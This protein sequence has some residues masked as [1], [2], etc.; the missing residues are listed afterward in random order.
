MLCS[1]RDVCI[2]VGC[3]LVTAVQLTLL[4]FFYRPALAVLFIVVA[5]GFALHL[6]YK[7]SKQLQPTRVVICTGIVTSFAGALFTLLPIDMGARP[8]LVVVAACVIPILVLVRSSATH[9]RVHGVQM[10]LL[11]LAA[12]V[13][14]S[15]DAALKAKH[16]LGLVNQIAAWLLSAISLLLPAFL[17]STTGPIACLESAFLALA[18]PLALLS[19]SYE[20]LYYATLGVIT[21]VWFKLEHSMRQQLYD[22]YTPHQQHLRSVDVITCV[23]GFVLSHGAFFGTG[24]IASISHFQLASVYRFTT[25]FSPGLMGALLMVKIFLP[26]VLIACAFTAILKCHR[27]TPM[28]IFFV[29]VGIA[30]VGIIQFFFLVKNTGSWLEIGNSISHFAIASLYIIV[31]PLIFYISGIYMWKCTA[32]VEEGHVV[33]GVT[34]SASNRGRGEINHSA[35]GW[36]STNESPTGWQ[37]TNGRESDEAWQ[38][39][40]MID[41]ALDIVS[42]SQSDEKAD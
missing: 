5:A 33:L 13:V 22:A 28:A 15:T 30:E 11:I 7:P 35:T 31:S 16:G 29:F 12:V 40:S 20:L 14:L 39:T 4:A 8:M 2:A 27:I 23:V 36:Q 19:L 10:V 41:I 17:P 1:H 37:S 34:T 42:I 32:R 21:W 24:N 25:V 26:I 38:M 3:G 18:T 9:R 6:L